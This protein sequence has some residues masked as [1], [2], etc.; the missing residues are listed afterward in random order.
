MPTQELPTYKG[1]PR[2]VAIFHRWPIPIVRAYPQHNV[3]P[4]L[5]RS[6]SRASL[7]FVGRFR[8]GGPSG[9]NPMEAP[10]RPA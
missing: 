7:R 6:D 10:M 1:M 2:T 5:G 3:G 4:G 8:F 9:E